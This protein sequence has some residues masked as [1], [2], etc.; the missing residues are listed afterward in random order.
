MKK[1]CLIGALLFLLLPAS[2]CT[3][4][5]ISLSRTEIDRIFNTRVIAIDKLADGRVRLAITTRK[6]D[7]STLSSGTS[8]E[9]SEILVGTGDT[10]FSAVR[11]ILT[12]SSKKPHYGHAEFILFGEDTARDGIMPYL[13]FITRNYEFRYNAKIYIIKGDTAYDFINKSDEGDLYLAERLSNLEDNSKSLSES[14]IV[15]LSDIL[16]L[17][18]KKDIAT[19]IPYIT[20]QKAPQNEKKS[21]GSYDLALQGYSIF[22]G[23][24]LQL[25]LTNI[26]SR[27]LNW[28][29]NRIYSGYIIVNAPDG[30]RVSLEIINSKTVIKPYMDENGLSCDIKVTFNTNIAETTAETNIFTPEGFLYLERQQVNDI[31]AQLEAVLQLAQKEN[32]DIFGIQTNFVIQYPMM[33]NEFRNQ[34]QELFPQIKF[35]L[36]VNSNINRTYMLKET[37]NSM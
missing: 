17:I 19:Y 25:F 26:Q 22:K 11:N 31:K 2:G 4:L 13:D 23:D 10:V 30:N 27:A 6:T 35:N 32:L 28:V 5:G 37:T 29:K 7:G 20:L 3:K 18:E 1:L 14:S 33:K 36:E 9:K 8:N 15:T 34:W 24:R 16:F 12:Y 21:S